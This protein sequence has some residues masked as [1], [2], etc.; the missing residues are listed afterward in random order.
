VRKT[1]TPNT[2]QTAAALAAFLFLAA[3]A[4]ASVALLGPPA[5]AAPDAPPAEFSAGRAM[6]HVR[7]IAERP[8]PT[9]TVEN[10]R[11][12]DYLVGELRRLGLEP[13]VQ[14][15]ESFAPARPAGGMALGARIENVVA[16]RE[17][18]GTGNTALM[19]A[20]HYDSVPTAPGATDDA[21]GVAAILETLR[22]L[23]E[24]PPPAGDLVVLF[25]DG[26][27]LGLLGARAFAAEHPWMKDVALVLN[28]EGRGAGGPS[29][30]FETSA[31]NGAL[32]SALGEAAPRPVASSLMYEAYQRL[33]ND[34]DMTVFKEA[35]AAGLNFAYAGRLTH[36]HTALDS[37]AELDERSLQHHGSYALALARRFDNLDARG[38][39]GDDAVFFNLFGPVLVRYPLAA[40]A[41]LTAL[42]VAAFAAVLVIGLRRRRLSASGPAAGGLA[43]LLAATAAGVLAAA[44]WR[45]AR[46]LHA[47]F[48]S[49]PWQ[50]PYELGLYELGFVFL[51]FGA[52]AGVYA[53][54]FRRRSDVDLLAGALVGWALA[55]V[56]TTALVPAGSYLFAWPFL[57]ALV[58]FAYLV[59]RRA[60]ETGGAALFVTALCA[61]PG[62]ALVAPIVY[63]FV[64]MM[65]LGL[66]GFLMV[67]VVLALGLAL[68][69][70]R[71][72]VGRRRWLLPGAAAL[73]GL[74]LIAGAVTSAGFDARRK[75]VNHL[76]YQLDADAA[77]AYWMSFDRERDE[78]TAQFLTDSARRIEPEAWQQW[79]RRRFWQD[80]APP[81]P[82]PAP[83]L[84]MLEDRTAGEVRTVRLRVA[85]ARE[86]RAI[87]INAT[88]PEIQ[89]ATINGRAVWSAAEAAGNAPAA[90]G[91][92]AT[93]AP[94]RLTYAAPPVGGFE[95]TVET[96]A[97]AG[98]GLVVEDFTFGLPTEALA[99]RRPRPDNMMPAPNYRWSDT[100]IVRRTFNFPPAAGL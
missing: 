85:S 5:A 10:A 31:G 83:A 37:P 14:A 80:D 19:L 57:S 25:T 88:G 60:E 2:G 42:L 72:L 50:T 38:L 91:A 58:G 39:K 23:R 18:T 20:A 77:R 64:M 41:P 4:G 65:G 27:E 6:R 97:G 99:G 90:G 86:A 81:L 11:V 15:A 44:V 98:L 7:I 67:L 70:V 36:Y 56:L 22:A 13:Q 78:W 55:L 21:A 74:I 54:L 95:L 17:G 9:G 48:E 33:P 3:V 69:L 53:S 87:T 29:M 92:Q 68:P 62:F 51:T 26:E 49:L 1:L 94:F 66:V 84:E 28:F 73:A 12:R 61:A 24:G 52:A 82:L 79:G 59:L 40:A 30:M 71:A 46:A 45:A 96:R 32:V 43:L 89:R 8:H 47:G 16:R 75:R 63:L 76:F 93:P 34:T 35:G 100:T